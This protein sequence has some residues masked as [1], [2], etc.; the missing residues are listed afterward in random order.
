MRCLPDERLGVIRASGVPY[1]PAETRR[2]IRPGYVLSEA[3]VPSICCKGGDEVSSRGDGV[4]WKI[5]QRRFSCEASSVAVLVRKLDL[6]LAICGLG[7]LSP[8]IL[9]AVLDSS[10]NVRPC[11]PVATQPPGGVPNQWISRDSSSP[12]AM[13]DTAQCQRGSIS[14]RD[15]DFQSG[16]CDV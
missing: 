2:R 13:K 9:G 6:V 3:G 11:D 10:I 8:A 7:L 14:R 15:P 1:V 12:R 16:A 5:D 4:P